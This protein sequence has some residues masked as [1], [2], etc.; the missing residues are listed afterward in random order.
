MPLV[1]PIGVAGELD[2]TASILP[3]QRRHDVGGGRRSTSRRLLYT[4]RWTFCRPARTGARVL[5]CGSRGISSQRRITG[6]DR[7]CSYPTAPRLAEPTTKRLAA[8]G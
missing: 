1:E 6:S 2:R 8:P 4:H 5:C 7:T 3:A